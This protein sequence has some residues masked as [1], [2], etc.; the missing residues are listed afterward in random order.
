MN[1]APG[2]ETAGDGVERPASLNKAW[3]LT[4]EAFDRLLARLDPDR[5][6]A[7]QRYEQIRLALITFF[8]CR[9]SASPED[10]VDETVNRVARRLLEGKEIYA[11]NP[12]SYFYGVA[13]NVLKE[14]WT[15]P[16]RR[17]AALD[18][19]PQGK[20][21]AP[22]LAGTGEGNPAA[23]R[24]EQRLECLE[25]CLQELASKERALIGG[26]YEGEGGIKIRNRERLARTLDIGL[27]ALRIRALRI[28]ERLEACVERGLARATGG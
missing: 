8:E 22:A 9:G 7:G 17:A 5:E 25:H 2:P 18:A 14:S 19:V 4:R 16:D 20:L 21:A 15:S 13:R 27:N 6:R 11:T 26:Y 24:D 1:P 3:V 12:A 28:R 10:A 23:R